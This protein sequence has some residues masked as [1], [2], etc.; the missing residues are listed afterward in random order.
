MRS[1]K[2]HY[3][4]RYHPLWHPGYWLRRASKAVQRVTF[5][6]CVSGR[7]GSIV[8]VDFNFDTTDDAAFVAT[9]QEALLLIHTVSPRQYRRME[10][11]VR[12]IVNAELTAGGSYNYLLR[13]CEVDFARYH[14]ERHSDDYEWYMAEYAS[15]LVH[16]AT[17]ARL[18]RM[19]FS[20]TKQ[21]RARIERICVAE[22][23]RFLSR[24]KSDR[25]DFVKDLAQPFDEAD[26]Q[27][28][29]NA[30][31]WER[32][33]KLLQRIRESR[34]KSARGGSDDGDG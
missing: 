30:S 34:R 21:T 15:T 16:E 17:H 2:L 33:K 31:R 26:W 25:Y 12:F 13:A 11:D 19:Y 27:F 20:Y 7:Y 29:W 14:L 8:V 23:N 5:R 6:H 4:L 24:L 28:S 10:R 32:T 3:Y 1:R 22:Q 9:T 18:D